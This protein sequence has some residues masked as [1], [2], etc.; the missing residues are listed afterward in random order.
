M[1]NKCLHKYDRIG[2]FDNLHAS[3]KNKYLVPTLT[4]EVTIWPYKGHFCSSSLGK[5]SVISL[6]KLFKTLEWVIVLCLFLSSLFFTKDTMEKYLSDRTGFSSYK[7]NRTE[8]PTTVI[9]FAP[10]GSHQCYKLLNR[11]T[12]RKNVY[13]KINFLKPIVCTE[14]KL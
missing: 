5:M 12:L 13:E 4:N 11:L 6:D 1:Y 10:I 7:E 14:M 9:C 2:F 8:F 3:F